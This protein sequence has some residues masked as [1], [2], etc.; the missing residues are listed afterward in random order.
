M[1]DPRFALWART[2]VNYSVT[3]GVKPGDRVAIG[4]GTAA[5]PLLRAI[6]RAT[7]DAGGYPVLMPSFSGLAADL[8]NMATTTRFNTSPPLRNSRGSKPTS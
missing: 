6:Y 7:L 3:G 4:G 2:L 8:L 5:E 1:S